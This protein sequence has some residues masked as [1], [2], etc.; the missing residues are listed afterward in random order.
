VVANPL[1]FT[2]AAL[3]RIGELGAWPTFGSF[4]L[5]GTRLLALLSEAGLVREP[6]VVKIFL[7]EGWVIGPFPTTDALDFHLSQLPDGLDVEWLVVPYSISDPQLIER[8][9]RHAIE[10][11]GGVRVGIGDNPVAD[12]DA[13]NAEWVERAAK[14]AEAAGR[15]IATATE[16]RRRIGT[17]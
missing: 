12:P 3:E 2:L 11:G 6:V 5:G 7:S 14:W 9:C 8:L 1:W 16:I 17:R 10:R 4:D 15:P 13:T